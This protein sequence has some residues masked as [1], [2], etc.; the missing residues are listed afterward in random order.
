MS[1]P[2][3]VLALA[4]VVGVLL[5]LLGGG[6]TIL[7]VPL[8]TYVADMPTKEAMAASTVIVGVTAAINLAAPS[9]RGTVAWRTG[10]LFG[11][12]TMA[13]AFG[14]GAL[15]ARLPDTLLMVLFAVLMAAAGLAMLRRGSTQRTRPT[16]RAVA[17]LAQGLGV[18]LLTGMVGAG[19]GFLIVPALVML[20]GL[21]MP[22]AV[23]TSLLVIAMKSLT[24]MAGYL[25]TVS[26]DWPTTLLVTAAMVTGSLIGSSIARRVPASALKRSFGVLVLAMSLV[27]LTVELPGLW[28]LG[29]GF[30]VSVAGVALGSWSNTGSERGDDDEGSRPGSP[31]QDR[32]PPQAGPR[33]ARLGDQRRGGR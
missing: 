6:G 20:G 9:R 3:L 8:L 17:V 29:A 22:I 24:G 12:A 31:A 33:A 26:I 19:G 27:V 5:G 23:S 15:G 4:A 13:G 32:E 10:A 11:A 1:L 21:S 18:G 16:P 2:P 14:G 25:T 7:A 30:L 28:G